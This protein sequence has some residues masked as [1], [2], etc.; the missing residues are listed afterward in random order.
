M[1]VIF[2]IIKTL[3]RSSL[4][5]VFQVAA[6]YIY[7]VNPIYKHLYSLLFTINNCYIIIN[8]FSKWQLHLHIRNVHLQLPLRRSPEGLLRV[9]HDGLAGLR[10]AQGNHGAAHA[11]VLV[12]LAAEINGPENHR[13]TIGKWWFKGIL[14]DF[15]GFTLW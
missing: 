10:G 12:H 14:W 8:S 3:E 9:A 1:G 6:A 15:M 4:S 7:I 11:G 2:R 13:K 5:R